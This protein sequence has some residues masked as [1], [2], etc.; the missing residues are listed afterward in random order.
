MRR[1]PNPATLRPAFEARHPT[2][3]EFVSSLDGGGNRTTVY[4]PT[5]STIQE[6]ASRLRFVMAWPRNA[7]NVQAVCGNYLALDPTKERVLLRLYIGGTKECSRW[8]PVRNIMQFW[9][10]T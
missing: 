7:P 6:H 4:R 10:Y 5:F 2:Q 3:D 8:F 9:F 1:K